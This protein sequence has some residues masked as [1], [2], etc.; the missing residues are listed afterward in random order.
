MDLHLTG[1]IWGT[2]V[3]LIGQ[4][5]QDAKIT[6]W[7]P[8]V[9]VILTAIFTYYITATIQE[10]NHQKELK[11]LA[12]FEQIDVITKARKVYDDNRLHPVQEDPTKQTPGDRE[13]MD[14]EMV[15]AYTFQA[16]KFKTYAVWEA[17]NSII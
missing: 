3:S 10:R 16:A 5:T 9:A 2:P 8:L 12:Y 11:R 4:T 17:R 14:R 6:D 7:L 13:R 1:Q 15:V